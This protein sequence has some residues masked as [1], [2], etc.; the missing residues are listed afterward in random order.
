MTAPLVHI[1]CG[2]GEVFKMTDEVNPE[3]PTLN[4]TRSSATT[5]FD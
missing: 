3:K 2:T 4:F 5:T 1:R